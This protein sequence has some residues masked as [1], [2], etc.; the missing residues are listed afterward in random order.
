MPAVRFLHE[1][2]FLS[3]PVTFHELPG[4]IGNFR[5]CVPLI[6]RDSLSSVISY[7]VQVSPKRK[8]SLEAFPRSGL[9]SFGASAPSEMFGFPWLACIY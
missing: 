7:P 3:Q 6:H 2:V 5:S 1:A 4:P 9:R 8:R